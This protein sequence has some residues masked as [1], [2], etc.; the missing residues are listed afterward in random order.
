MLNT[1]RQEITAL[2]ATPFA[3]AYPGI[4]LV[5]DNAPFDWNA[6]PPFF[7]TLEV[8]FYSG[9]QISMSANP[10]TRYKGYVYVTT[11]AKEGTGSAT[12]LNALSWF[13]TNLGYKRTTSVQIEAPEPSGMGSPKGWFTE[14]SKFYFYADET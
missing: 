11:Y 14:E 9:N 10:K 8:K 3:A 1:I 6:P 5:T 4:P 13:A 2:V 7:V 12:S